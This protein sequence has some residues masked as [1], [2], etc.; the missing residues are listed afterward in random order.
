M[1]LGI[2]G[3][4]YK[5]VVAS[6]YTLTHHIFLRLRSPKSPGVHLRPPCKEF[7]TSGLQ[8]NAM[9]QSTEM[10]PLVSR[11]LN[12]LKVLMV[13]FNMLVWISG[14]CNIT[15]YVVCAISTQYILI[16][17]HVTYRNCYL[18]IVEKKNKYVADI[19]WHAS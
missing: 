19:L 15:N 5:Q 7:K 4:A 16:I 12:P 9:G 10:P 2:S 18:P 8:R 13:I 14:V 6:Q 17:K 1:A 11:L 3:K